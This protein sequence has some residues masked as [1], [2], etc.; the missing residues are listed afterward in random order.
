MVNHM[1]LYIDGNM[2]S[3]NTLEE[4]VDF[5]KRND[6]ILTCSRADWLDDQEFENDGMIVVS[7]HVPGSRNLVCKKDNYAAILTY[8]ILI[9]DHIIEVRGEEDL[10]Y[11]A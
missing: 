3:M 10:H 9:S 1:R 7:S 4:I 8:A 11:Y 2:Y 6:I 5:L